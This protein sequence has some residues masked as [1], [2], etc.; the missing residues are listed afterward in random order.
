M[1]RHLP[2]LFVILSFCLLIAIGLTV[3][4]IATRSLA[5]SAAQ[6][7]PRVGD[8]VKEI[9]GYR[10][11]SKVNNEPQ[12]MPRIT[13]TLC[14]PVTDTR[15]DDPQNPHRNKYVTVYVN[16][17]GRQ[18][19][20]EQVKPRFPTGSV[21]VKEKLPDKASQAPELLTVI[22]KRGKGFNPTSGDWEY[23]VVDGTGTNVSAQGKLENCQSCHIARPGTD[24]VFRTYL[25]DEVLSKLK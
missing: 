3:T 22:I 11:W 14:A 23:M 20:L 15:A 12:L 13:A 21:I 10:S 5:R 1:D 7:V 4:Y 6:P 2:R 8:Q 18:A 9:A 17:I 25:P 16:D 19:M 24:Y